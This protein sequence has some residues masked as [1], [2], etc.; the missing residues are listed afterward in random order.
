MRT[1]I[2][3]HESAAPPTPALVRPIAYLDPLAAFAPFRDAPYALLLHGCGAHEEAR[4][5][6]LFLDPSETLDAFDEDAFARLRAWLQSGG[7]AAD[8]PLG[9]GAAGLF[10]YDFAPACDAAMPAACDARLPRLALGLY[11]WLIAFDHREQRGFVSARSG[12]AMRRAESFL[13][14]LG[15]AFEPSIAQGRVEALDSGDWYETRVR[16]LIERIRAGDLYQANLSRRFAGRLGE[17][18]HPY[19]LFARLCAQSP[20]PFAAYMRLE[21]CAIVSNSPERFVSTR[22]EEDDLRITTSPIKGTRPRGADPAQDAAFAQELLASAKDRA[23]NV[24]IVDL[25][26]NDLSRVSRPGTVSVP[27]LA[28][29]E[30]FANVHHLVSTIEST[31][32]SGA[33]AFDLMQAAFPPGSITGAPKIKSMELIADMEGAARGA[34]YGAL[35]WFGADG[36]M[37]SSV[38]IRTATCFAE[39]GGWGVEFRVGAGI[40]ADSDPLEETRETETK[41]SKLIAAIRGETR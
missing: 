26:R 24:M 32:K 8:L 5:S 18:D 14:L 12:E 10:T 9:W 3:P 6:F 23:E 39:S 1:T 33:D 36:A 17:G 30:S 13:P 29:L 16:S 25:M 4:W 19:D 35:A 20:A 41:A 2:E 11:D 31:M 15:E 28:A 7:A 21:H 38:L 37:D 22:R 40:V 27:K 34:N